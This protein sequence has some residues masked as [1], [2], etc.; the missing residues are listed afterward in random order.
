VITFIALCTF[1]FL[2]V[3]FVWQAGISLLGEVNWICDMVDNQRNHCAKFAG[4][5]S[6]DLKPDRCI[7]L[8]QNDS[9]LYLTEDREPCPYHLVPPNAISQSAMH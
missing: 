5:E 7:V 4:F 9:Y 8:H 3:F 6:H 1:K 2:L